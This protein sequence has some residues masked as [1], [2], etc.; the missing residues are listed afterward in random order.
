MRISL[1]TAVAVV[2]LS[3]M[4]AGGVGLESA[5]AVTTLCGVA[6]ETCEAMNRKQNMTLLE[7]SST[8]V[9]F[10]NTVINVTCTS[11]AFKA[12]TEAEVGTPLPAKISAANA[13]LFGGCTTEKGKECMVTSVNAPYKAQIEWS[14]ANNGTFKMVNGGSGIPAID[15]K[16]GLLLNCRLNV[17]IEYTMEGGNPAKIKVAG[18]V[19]TRIS[20][21]LCPTETQLVVVYTV[22]APNPVY[23]AH[24]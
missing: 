23:V 19:L 7:M 14:A 5:Q 20:G 24:T 22:N 3:S 8:Q 21:P 15:L 1:V 13:P 2:C 18:A 12:E 10:L 6:Q 11:G 4:G 16:C 9:S 17:E